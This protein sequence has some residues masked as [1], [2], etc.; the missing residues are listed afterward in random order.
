MIIA[1][2]FMASAVV[3]VG[4]I[5]ACL[6]MGDTLDSLSKENAGLRRTAEMLNH[7]LCERERSE[8]RDRKQVL[9]G[10]FTQR[11]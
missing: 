1:L 10:N 7:E 2:A 8:V 4:C 11:G 9:T 5:V 3:V 6:E